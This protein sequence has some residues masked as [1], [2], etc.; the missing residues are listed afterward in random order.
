MDQNFQNLRRGTYPKECAIRHFPQEIRKTSLMIPVFKYKIL[1]FVNFLML[2]K[3]LM[4]VAYL[5]L[6]YN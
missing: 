2:L 1:F 4:I 5:Y 3:H 6:I